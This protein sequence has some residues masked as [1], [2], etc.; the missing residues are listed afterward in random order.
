ML[1]GNILIC[2]LSHRHAA[3]VKVEMAANSIAVHRRTRRMIEGNI[4]GVAEDPG[5]AISPLSTRRGLPVSYM[6]GPQFLIND[7]Y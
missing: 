4:L 5:A 1:T 6:L 2:H 7:K 3:A